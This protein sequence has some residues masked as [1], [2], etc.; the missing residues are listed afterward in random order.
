MLKRIADA[1]IKRYYSPSYGGM[2]NPYSGMGTQSDKTQ[3][4][5][6]SPTVLNQITLDIIYRQ[7]WAAKK[8]IDIPVDDSFNLLRVSDNMEYQK[9]ARKY[10]DLDGKIRKAIIASRLYGGSLLVIMS[11]E[12]ELSN[13]LDYERIR[14]DDVSNLWI[15]SKWDAD[16][17]QQ[18]SNPWDP[19]YGKT[20]LYNIRTI[21]GNSIPVHSS[22]C[23][24]FD[25]I[26]SPSK[27]SFSYEKQGWGTSI[28]YPVLS[29]IM[30]EDSTAR[31]AAQLANEKSILVVQS[32]NWQ[33]AV[34]GQGD[35]DFTSVAQVAEQQSMMKS[36]YRTM[37]SSLEEDIKRVDAGV[38]GLGDIMKENCVRLAAAAGIPYTRFLSQSP[39][40]LNATGEHDHK[41]YAMLIK[42]IQR[43]LMEP[44]YYKLD[45]VLSRSLGMDAP[46][47]FEF[48]D[49]HKMSENE[50]AD[51]LTKLIGSGI[52]DASVAK[53]YARSYDTNLGSILGEK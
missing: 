13:P 3:N 24:R 43:D 39:G 28:L 45:Q 5:Y 11:T 19:N 53:D 48:P 21:D 40:G 2:R 20:D 23:I 32:E 8:M 37:Y 27:I 17:N 29:T 30:S 38:S 44:A 22:R 34:S 12:D 16:I 14:A 15:V 35:A 4:S 41:N 47:S 25:G 18:I 42:S 9:Y 46:E 6:F 7:S 31:A 51:Y 33:D 50:M 26:S 49:V 52:I 1:I 10:F 36:V